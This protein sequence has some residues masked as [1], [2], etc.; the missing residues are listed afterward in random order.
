LTVIDRTACRVRYSPLSVDDDPQGVISV[1]VGGRGWFLYDVVDDQGATVAALRAV[2]GR[3][4]EGRACTHRVGATHGRRRALI[5][6]AAETTWPAEALTNA[7]TALGRCCLR[8]ASGIRGSRWLTATAF[9][10]NTHN[11]NTAGF[12]IQRS[13]NPGQGR[14]GT[15]FGDSGGPILYDDTDV[16]LGVNSFVI[17]NQ[18]AGVGFAYRIDQADVLAWILKNAD[19]TYGNIDVVVV[20]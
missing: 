3:R 5:A 7:M 19:Y 2:V 20:P 15:C 1:T 11:T 9:I 18:W 16:I 4:G 13:R 12:N 14:G 8:V 6:N 10:V 17:N